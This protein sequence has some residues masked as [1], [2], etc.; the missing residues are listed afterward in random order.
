MQG[1][2]LIVANAEIRDEFI[3][4]GMERLQ[5]GAQ[6]LEV[7]E[8]VASLVEDDPAEHTVGYGGLPNVLGQV[9]LDASIMDGATLR[10]G[11][12]AALHG[13]RHPIRVARQVMERLPHV[14]LVGEGAN[15]FAAE[16]GAERRV[17]ISPGAAVAWAQRLQA[18]CADGEPLDTIELA[19]RALRASQG[20][21]TM[22]VIV[23]DSAGNL[24]S[25]VTT[26]GIAWKYPGRL[27]DS[28]IIGAGNYCDNRYGAATC[29]GL[30][31][32]AIRVSAAAQVVTL[33]RLG[34][35][36]EAAARE[37]TGQIAHLIGTSHTPNHMARA[38]W[39]RILVVDA[40]G[41]FSAAAT[42]PGLSFKVHV[43]GESRP[44]LCEAASV[45]AS[46]S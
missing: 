30:G 37:V 9:E 41:N 35:T 34:W 19:T 7:A 21:D 15:R 43:A 12:V 1:P 8:Y 20:S 42:R 4:A 17:M 45:G 27:G 23:R 16:I 6:A 44:R 31:E 2:P 28:P 39:V 33:L 13:F 3:V 46:L 25:A 40:Q 11:A 26:S 36:A 14:L 38:D 10:A 22:N 24:S 5:A 32:A 18:I 29:M